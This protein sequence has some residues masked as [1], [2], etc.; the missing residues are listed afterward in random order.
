MAAMRKM[1]ILAYPPPAIGVYVR[2]C[3]R[4]FLGVTFAYAAGAYAAETE[5][6]RHSLV[7][8]HAEAQRELQN[9]L[10]NASLY[11]ELND[12]NPATLSS[13][14][15][16]SINEALQIAKDYKRVRVRSGGNQ[17]YPVYSKSHALV[18]W[19]GRAEIRL[20]SSDFEAAS[21]LIGRLQTDMRLGSIQFAVSQETRRNAENALIAEAIAAFKARAEIIRAALD[22]RSYKLERLKVTNGYNAPRPHFEAMRATASAQEV[23]PPN[24]EAGVSIVTVTASGTIEVI[25]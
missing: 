24:F 16:N 13:A 4:F 7:E 17:T 11:V 2:I 15:N 5:L 9:D 22:G 21:G 14:L 25:D 23:S 3:I 19:R 10:L 20:E 6:A 8:L 12:A 18:A 1:A